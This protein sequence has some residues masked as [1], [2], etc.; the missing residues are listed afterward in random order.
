MNND[1]KERNYFV[2]TFLILAFLYLWGIG[3]PMPQ[4]IMSAFC[5]IILMVISVALTRLILKQWR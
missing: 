4:A 2:V 5:M 1:G 3:V